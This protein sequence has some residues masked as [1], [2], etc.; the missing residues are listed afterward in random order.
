MFPGAGQA[1]TRCHFGLQ[2][3]ALLS[4]RSTQLRDVANENGLT[5]T[6]PVERVVLQFGIA[7][8]DT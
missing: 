3:L 2:T 1:P 4:S 6:W 5:L 7:A 8:V